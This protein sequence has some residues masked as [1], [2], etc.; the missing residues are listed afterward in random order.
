MGSER[1]QV[2]AVLLLSGL[3]LA[4][5]LGL[6][7]SPAADNPDPEQL[8]QEAVDSADSEPI[9]GVR[10][11][12][13]QR[14]DQFEMTTVAVT[15]QPPTHSRIEVLEAIET[16]SRS[17][18]TISNESTMWRYFQD[19]QRAVRVD[20]DR[21]VAERTQTFHRHTRELLDQYEATYVG[22][23]RVENRETHVV[24][25]T[26]PDDTAL[27]LSLD[28]QTGNTDYQFA[29]EEASDERWFV[30]RE[31]L[32]I[33][34]ETAYPVKQEVEWTDKEGD[35]VG[36]NIRTYHELTV[37]AEID[38]D[39]TFD[40]DPPE[41]AT[42]VDPTV[43]ET[44]TYPSVDSAASAV[45][46]TVPEPTIP[47]GYELEGA[48]VQTV[49]DD[50]GVMLTYTRGGQ[51]ITIHV[52]ERTLRGDADRIVDSNVGGVDG[53]LLTV[54]GRTSLA[55]DCGDLSYRVSGLPEVNA[56][57]SIADSIGCD[58]APPGT[59]S[60]TDSISPVPSDSVR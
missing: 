11:D 14:D 55:W 58:S 22:T 49:D 52:S 48:M 10:T 5:F 2:V 33:D 20:A 34:T 31:T 36:S 54:D 15:R 26:P 60:S 19:E 12:V 47:S 56:L 53:T 28:I 21:Q 30:T 8:V 41:Q 1:L 42:V 16:D 4:P 23:E 40:F 59:A 18:L 39:E 57:T 29:L 45:E 43:P 24:E 35:V 7:G 51:T 27:E 13:F 46:F 50:Q 3:L 44:E 17:D 32:W 38:E 25:L 37:G 9:K 6:G